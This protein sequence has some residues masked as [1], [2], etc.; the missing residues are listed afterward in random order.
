MRVVLTIAAKDLRILLRDRTN[1][2]FVIVFPLAIA[3]FFGSIFGG[4]S[5]SIPIA[6]VM[7]SAGPVATDFA[8]ALEK[9]STL[10]VRMLPTR[11]EGDASVRLGRVAACVILPKTFDSDLEKAMAGS[12]AI[13]E[14]HCDPARQAESGLVVGKLNEHAMRAIVR[15]FTDP[16]IN[17]KMLAQSKLALML[18]PNMTSAQRERVSDV[19][20]SLQELF[21]ERNREAT[22]AAA[23]TSVNVAGSVNGDSAINTVNGNTSATKKSASNTTENLNVPGSTATAPAAI[24]P[25]LSLPIQ[26]QSST[27]TNDSTEPPST[28]AVTFPQGLAWGFVGCIGAF[29]AG[30]AEE[31]RRGTFMRLLLAPCTIAT[32][33]TGKSLACFTACMTMSVFMLLVATLGF[34]V[35]VQNWPLLALAIAACSFAFSGFTMALSGLFK[36]EGSARSAGNA[37]VLVLVMIGGGTIPLTFMPPFLR[38]ASQASPFSW[39]ILSIEGA[40]WRG[41]A[42]TEMLPS[43][44]ILLFIGAL[45]LLLGNLFIQKRART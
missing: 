17:S 21:N 37:I 11:E 39:A 5:R 2:F 12:R 6:V 9:D 14:V 38:A 20:E 10:S 36:Y 24:D 44:G 45:G 4:G 16:K 32:V 23:E 41:F 13:I 3:I 31:R 1:A 29:G 8:N 27:L 26:I 42:F 18:N 19:L 7:E 40:V 34:R 25:F 35:S 30:M 22:A 43:L 33:L 28:Y 15:M